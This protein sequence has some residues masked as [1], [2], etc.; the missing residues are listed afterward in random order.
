[1]AI[2]VDEYTRVIVQGITGQAGRFHTE[3]CMAYG[4]QVVGGVS[5]G[6]GGASVCGVPVYDTVEEAVREVECTATLVFVPPQHAAQA[7]VDAIE[8]GVE[9]VVCITEGIPV[10]DMFIVC[11]ALR[12]HPE[13][14]LVGPN[15]PGIISPGKCM[16][17]IMP[18]EIHSEGVA[19]IVSRSGTLLYEAVLQTTAA[20]LGQSTC[21]GIGGDHLI[22]LNIVDAISLFCDDDATELIIL[23][24]EIGATYE[25]DA[26]EWIQQHCTKPVVA[27]VA[28]TSAPHGQVMGH[29]SAI[30][31]GNT[32][33]AQHKIRALQDAGITVIPTIE[34]FVGDA[35]VGDA[36]PHAPCQRSSAPLDSPLR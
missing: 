28:G 20:G 27:Y 26:A 10:H 33:S 7:I 12:Q 6:K 22:G 11:A 18:P 23:I 5:P 14:R 3:R 35:V 24:G 19:G 16:M 25:E 36:V 2:V 13:V 34:A 31:T 21:I 8:C 15:C 30:V 4:T 32:G 9:L 1:M 29:A 17:G